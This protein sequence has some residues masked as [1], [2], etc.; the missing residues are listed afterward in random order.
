MLLIRICVVNVK[1]SLLN[2]ANIVLKSV[3]LFF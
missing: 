2:N 1:T 3:I